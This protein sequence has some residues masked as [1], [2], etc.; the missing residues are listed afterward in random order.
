[1]ILYYKIEFLSKNLI[2]M[3]VINK[4]IDD[5]VML[6]TMKGNDPIFFEDISIDK[7]NDYFD[8]PIFVNQLK[9][10]IKRIVPLYE[11]KYPSV[12]EGNDSFGK[13]GKD[14]LIQLIRDLDLLD[15]KKIKELLVLLH[16]SSDNYLD[17]VTI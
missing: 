4:I 6:T 8:N 17:V 12:S 13:E 9:N 14:E 15:S 11:G 16:F 1:M 5:S 10:I 3:S 2:E 7:L